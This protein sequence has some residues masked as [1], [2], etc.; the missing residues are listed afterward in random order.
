MMKKYPNLTLA[1]LLAVCITA[2]SV[3]GRRIHNMREA[4]RFYR[5]IITAS[6]QMRM[7]NHPGFATRISASEE[8]KDDELFAMVSDLAEEQLEAIPVREE[9]DINDSGEPFSV[10]VRYTKPTTAEEEGEVGLGLDTPEQRKRDKALY[11]FAASSQ[12]A[13]A[14][15]TFLACAREGQISGLG[16]VLDATT[17]YASDKSPANLATIFLGFR[18]MAANLVWLQVDKMWHEGKGHRMLPLMN[19]CVLLDPNFIDAYLVGAWHLSYNATAGKEPTAWDLRYFDTKHKVWSGPIEELYYQAI[20]FLEYGILNNP[21]EYRLHFDLGYAIYEEKLDDHYHAVEHLGEAISYYH[22]VWVPRTLYRIMGYHEQYEDAIDGWNRYMKKNPDTKSANEVAPRFIKINQGRIG[23]RDAEYE[24]T[25]AEAAE[26][27]AKRA[28]ANGDAAAAS[29]YEAQALDSR[30]EYDRLLAEARAIWENLLVGSG[31]EETA[32]VAALA[33]MDAIDKW[34]S[35]RPT[36]PD[37]AIALLEKARFDASQFY[38]EALDLIIEIKNDAG[39]PLALTE[40]LYV[41]RN[42]MAERHLAL[43][44]KSTIGLRFEFGDECWYQLGYDAEVAGEPVR[45]APDSDDLLKAELEYPEIGRIADE[46]DGPVVFRAGDTWYRYD[47]PKAPANLLRPEP[48][49]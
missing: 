48:R 37:E 5:W 14:R 18:K 44:P 25:R 7:T 11:A 15:A 16:T 20:D 31:G 9:I 26:E 43:L 47:A 39:I 42:E 1:L 33:R 4:E 28:A 46:F 40:T 41:N 36:G 32:A 19:S 8:Y 35:G 49:A 24:R 29:Q 45:L 27:L 6:N 23:E 21:R 17:F 12:A 38:W 10:L 2:G 13:D 34:H 22:D 30:Q 3:Q